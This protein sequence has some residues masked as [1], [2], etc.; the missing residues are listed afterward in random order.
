M[1]PYE[2]ERYLKIHAFFSPNYCHAKYSKIQIQGKWLSDLGF[3]A[4]K[5]VSV[6]IET[7]ENE[8]TKL[9]VKLVK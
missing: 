6:K 2:N 8:E 3:T 7:N 5:I 1:Y 9:V 4:G